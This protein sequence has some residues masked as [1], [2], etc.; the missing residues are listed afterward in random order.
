MKI[1][2][3]K[4]KN[5]FRGSSVVFL[6][7][8]IFE[9]I[10]SMFDLVGLTQKISEQNEKIEQIDMNNELYYEVVNENKTISRKINESTLNSVG[11]NGKMSGLIEFL[12]HLAEAKYIDKLNKAFR[13]D[14]KG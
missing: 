7:L 3:P 11:E 2:T 5:I 9:I 4:W 6:L 1:R 13:I 12:T 10:P 14:E 8:I